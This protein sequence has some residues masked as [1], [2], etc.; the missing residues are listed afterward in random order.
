M[1][2]YLKLKIPPP[3]VALACGVLIWQL[4]ALFG[5]E[6]A[7]P[8][9]HN[10]ALVIAATALAIDLSA[11]VIFLRD[12]TTIDPR[13]PHKSSSIVSGG[14]YCYTRNPMYLGLVL[15]LT[16]LMIWTGSLAG[17]LLIIAFVLYINHFQIRPEE[18][19]LTDRFGREYLAYKEKVRRWI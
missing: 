12:R 4:A 8:L 3:L 5:V 17:P 13:Y 2:E 14:I 10:M 19:H 15:L 7:Q 9:R 1:S 6:T 16:A 11:L 18:Q